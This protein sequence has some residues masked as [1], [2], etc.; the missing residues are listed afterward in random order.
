MHLTEIL[1]PDSIKVPLIAKGKQSALFELVDLLVE[2]TNISAGDKLREAVWER[3]QTRTTGI[4]HGIAIPHGKIK[5]CHQLCM[6]MGK[7]ADPIDFS[8]IDD[9][10]VSLIILLASP[11]DQTGPHIQ[12][13][14]QISRML[15]DQDFRLSLQQ[16]SSASQ[17]Y[18]LITAQEAKAVV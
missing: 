2:T 15:T 7:T 13:L 3:E 11:A 10:P 9:K 17:V 12:A 4:G 5:E 6:A 8:A 14:A 16:A 18:E 1:Q